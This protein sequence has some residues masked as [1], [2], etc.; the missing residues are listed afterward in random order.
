MVGRHTDFARQDLLLDGGPRLRRE[1]L[2]EIVLEVAVVLT[3]GHRIT[4][5][6]ILPVPG[7]LAEEQRAVGRLL[8]DGAVQEEVAVELLVVRLENGVVGLLAQRL[9]VGGTDDVAEK[10]ERVIG[11]VGIDVVLVPAI[12]NPEG[13]LQVL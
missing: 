10:P 6:S 1:E 5:A 4:L 9:V 7:G 13:G 11:I 8:V 3:A 12:T 2:G